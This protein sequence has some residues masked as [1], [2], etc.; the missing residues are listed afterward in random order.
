[1]TD[2]KLEN[3]TGAGTD[4]PGIFPGLMSVV[5]AEVE[6]QYDD[7]RISGVDYANVYMNMLQAV[8]QQSTAILLG[9]DL[10]N[11]QVDAARQNIVLSEEEEKLVI[12][13]RY[14][15]EANIADIV[16][17][18]A[19]I[20]LVGKQ[21]ELI[22]SQQAQIT[23]SISKTNADELLVEQ[24]TE[25]EKS[26]TIGTI[27]VNGISGLA[28]LAKQQHELLYKQNTQL[29]SAIAKENSEKLLI[30]QRVE[31]ESAETVG[32]V[33]TLGVSSVGGVVGQKLEKIWQDKKLV[34][35]QRTTETQKALQVT[36]STAKIDAEKL[37]VDEKVS[38]EAAQTTG[39]ID[40]NGISSIDGL[41][42]KQH[43]LLEVEKTKADKSNAKLTAEISLINQKTSS[44]EAQI[45]GTVSTVGDSSVGGVVGQTMEKIWQEKKLVED[46]RAT[47]SAQT[48]G[49]IDGGGNS[50]INGLLGEQHE[51]LNRQILQTEEATLKTG[52]EKDLLSQKKLTEE[53]QITG[54]VDGTT[55]NSAVGGVVG[56][57]MEL[58]HAQRK[59]FAHNAEHKVMRSL[60]EHYSIKKTAVPGE[61]P[62]D[63]L[64]N[65]A[66]GKIAKEAALSV[67]FSEDSLPDPIP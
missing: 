63:M 23:A 66:I 22:T 36:S 32:T 58:V 11:A 40:V 21:K 52:S 3:L 65:V 39:T 67:G 61:P 16:N 1:M 35:D 26:N 38:S 50:S 28:G 46:K 2:I 44:E 24:K 51:L 25:T 54:T 43:E 31:T 60:L 37:L 8:L 34:E 17:G 13:K 45:T 47:E 14:T 59:G 12:A 48:T 30:D 20:G 62:I 4:E 33:S 19:V 18:T 42:G 9:V 53:A 55:G 49:T 56:R 6:K 15:E 64:D 29:T 5:G 41:L 7:G 57:Q 10:A 27:D